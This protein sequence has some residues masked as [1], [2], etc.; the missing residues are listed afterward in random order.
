MLAHQSSA[1]TGEQH[2]VV[3]A[4]TDVASGSLVV[5]AGDRTVTLQPQEFAIIGRGV[6]A[7]ITVR[8]P[9]VSR[10]QLLIGFHGG[11]YVEDLSSSNGSYINGRRIS[12]EG[13]AADTVVRLGNAVQGPVVSIRLIRADGT[14]PAP[15]TSTPGEPTVK[16]RGLPAASGP[17][18]P[19]MP[20]AQ[21]PRP[22]HSPSPQAPPPRQHQAQVQHPP[23]TQPPKSQPDASA[24]WSI[25]PNQHMI[26]G[27]STASDVVLPDLHSPLQSARLQ[28]QRDGL[29]VQSRPR[30]GVYLNGSPV[31]TAHMREGDILTSGATDFTLRRQRLVPASVAFPDRGGLEVDQVSFTLGNGRK[32]LDHV[33]FSA[34]R[35]TLTAVIGPSGA[36]KSTLVKAISGLNRVSEGRASF[37]GFDIH[38]QYAIAKKRIGM[39]PQDDVIHR[40]L[41]LHQ[42]LKYAARLRLGADVSAQERN[43]QIDK[44][45]QQLDL[46]AHLDTRIDKLSGGQR[47]RASVAMELLTEPSFLILDEPTSGLD[48][49]L[50]RQLMHEFR[51]LADG[52]RTVLVITH[53][54]ACLTLCDQIVVLVPGG[55]PAFI[56][57]PVQAVSYFGTADW[58]TIFDRLKSDPDGCRERWQRHAP[59]PQHRHEPRAEQSTATTDSSARPRQLLT[60]IRRQIALLL[61]DRGYSVFLLAVPFLVGLLP[62]VVPG[63]TGLTQVAGA[64]H[65]TE[66]QLILALLTIGAAFMGVAMTIRDL[67]SERSIFLRE[68]AV[69]LSI[70][71]YLL[72]KVI[73]YGI[74]GWIGAIVMVFMAGVVKPPPE[75]DGILGLGARTELVLAMGVTVTVCLML[76]LLLSALV[77]SQSQVMPVIIVVF[78]V[79]LVMI[80]GFIPLTDNQVLDGISRAVPA[81]WTMAMAA[82]STDLPH[83]LE[84]S[85]EAERQVAQSSMPATD[86]LWE[87]ELW[88][89]WSSLGIVIAM[90]AVSLAGA[91]ARLRRT[92]G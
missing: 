32:L 50:D 89:W 51:S 53:S 33:D 59:Q 67:V 71:C 41:K 48:P 85:D 72:S 76:G 69:N 38:R 7:Q 34:P 18:P 66:P 4:T 68:R 45:V 58:S 29:L 3:A 78:L 1:H 49:A 5:T 47:K 36:G 26:M 15:E 82:I 87:H 10:R 61:A 39:V 22:L 79:Q 12:R 13:I 9:L 11:W 31:T 52:D 56:G 6:A 80:G 42:A 40:H 25:A 21:R 44:A 23:Q 17:L 24:G 81:R 20:S 92:R 74:L 70:W 16:A 14:N 73:V 30:D 19:R 54:V 86:P 64:K 63:D 8:D 60:L 28:G 43:A 77:T 35:G 55:A 83:L 46:R 90:S 75:G 2:G 57:S 37:D 27:R 65:A 91:W 88:R 84:I 62:L